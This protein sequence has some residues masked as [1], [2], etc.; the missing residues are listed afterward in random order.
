MLIFGGKMLKNCAKCRE[1]LALSD[2]YPSA[3]NLG[4]L[5]PNCKKCICAYRRERYA[6]SDGLSEMRKHHLKRTYGLSAA[7]YERMLTRQGGVC[8][9]CG[10]GEKCIRNGK[11]QSLAVD[12]DHETGKVRGLLCSKCNQGLGHIED[13][14]SRVKSIIAY[15]EKHKTK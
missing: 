1:V 15:I 8:A 14:I 7:R 4:G 2:F 9:I 5:T 10:H 6:N 13:D 3:K 11:A 12:H